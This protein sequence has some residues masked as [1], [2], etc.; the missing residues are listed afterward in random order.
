MRL[1]VF[2]PP[3][4]Q[5]TAP[6]RRR[7]LW[8]SCVA[9]AMHDGYTDMIYAL[10]PVWQSE[11]GLDF[12][13]LAILRGIYAGTMATLQLSAGR[14]AQHLG[15]RTTLAI[16]T[17][18]AALGY[19]IAG[20][21]GGLF[22]LGVALAISG[23]GSSTQHPIASGAVS[24][25]Y[26]RDARGP[27]SVY[28]FSGD[29]GKSALPAAITLLVTLMPW[30]H[31]LWIVAGLGCVVAAVIALW[32]P[33]VPR[34]AGKPGAKEH[35][36]ARR[37]GTGGSGFPT[38]FSIGVLDTAVRM[39]LLTFLPFL[40]KAK[41]VSPQLLGTA[42]ALV[43]IGGAAGKFMCGWL[44][45]RM[46]VAGTVLLTEG[47]TAACIVAVMYLP[48]VLTMVLL[49]ILG[50]MLNGTSSV[51][52]GTVP[53]MS[54]PERTE[55][56]F[57]IFYTG[58]IASGALSPVLYGFLGDRIGVHGATYATALTALAIFPLALAL[59]P[60]LADDSTG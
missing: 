33:A 31:A 48:L 30:R 34:G 58:T 44:G 20:M 51:L 25:T 22:G 46:G 7:V 45:A 40:L 14:L 32:F 54:A 26:G 52:Y 15:S 9:H 18:L 60:H 53:E 11:F 27:L 59:R 47:G 28:N 8:L 12:A 2:S 42:L 38:L 39:G 13:A 21:S 17:L 35:A 36:S 29:L 1:P 56:A 50:M 6:P 4:M 55:R 3:A 5:E 10:L 57:A 41:G 49:P 37:S 16:G 19:A 24:R 23:G 43:F